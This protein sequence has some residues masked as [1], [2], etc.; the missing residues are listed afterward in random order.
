CTNVPNQHIVAE[1]IARGGLEDH[2][3]QIRELYRERK[4][5]ML[6]SIARHLGD[7]V[8]TTNPEGGFFLWLTLAGE[9]GEIDTRELFERALADGVAFIPGPA[10]SP[11]GR[12]RNALRLCFASS[13]PERIEEGI[14]RLTVSLEKM[15]A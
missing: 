6:D 8:T 7:R 13:T 5:A 3:S 14:R 15:V 1:Y 12:F 2:L 10:L 4:D 9:F 11:G